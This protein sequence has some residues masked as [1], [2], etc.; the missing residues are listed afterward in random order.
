[1]KI[2]PLLLLALGQSAYTVNVGPDY[3]HPIEGIYLRIE[4]E[5]V[6]NLTSNRPR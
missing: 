4:R 3:Q 2:Y 1:M 5:T 6:Y